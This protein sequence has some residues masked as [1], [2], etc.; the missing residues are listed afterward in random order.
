MYDELARLEQKIDMLHDSLKA[1]L[2]Q[3]VRAQVSA[4]IDKATAPEKV[5]KESTP[6]SIQTTPSRSGGPKST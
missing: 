6:K 3:Y 2:R 4:E 5:S 1:E